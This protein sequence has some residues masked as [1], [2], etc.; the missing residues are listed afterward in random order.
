MACNCFEEAK[1]KVR[2]TT[3]DPHAMIRGVFTPINGKI[4]LLP[5]MRFYIE[6]KRR[7]VPFVK[8]KVVLT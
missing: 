5:S 6:R 2:E 4:R 8:V 3:G 1:E 7:M